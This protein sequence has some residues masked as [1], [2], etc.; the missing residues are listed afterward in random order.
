MSPPCVVKLPGVTVGRMAVT[1][2]TDV[3][4]LADVGERARCGED[5]AGRRRS[6][7]ADAWRGTAR[8]AGRTERVCVG[9]ARRSSFSW[10]SL[11]YHDWPG[12]LGYARRLSEGRY[13]TVACTFIQG[14]WTKSLT[15]LPTRLMCEANVSG[16][17]S[18]GSSLIAS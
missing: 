12:F 11:T 9:P 7:G 3:A 15:N 5:C 4:L 10:F 18:Y 1:A 2:S 14:R 17:S 16:R 13:S 8:G 6:A